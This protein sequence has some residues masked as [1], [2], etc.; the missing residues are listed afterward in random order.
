MNHDKATQGL[1]EAFRT[2]TNFKILVG[3]I[4]LHQNAAT[5]KALSSKHV[6]TC[7]YQI[8]ILVFLL[9]THQTSI[10][11][12]SLTCLVYFYNDLGQYLVP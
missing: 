2:I 9:N 4:P 12:V 5:Q 1:K 6:V 10:Y 11:V 8:L 3:C 7:T